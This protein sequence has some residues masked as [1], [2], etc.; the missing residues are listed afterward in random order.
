LAARRDGNDGRMNS[1][2]YNAYRN[3][4][5]RVRCW[6][7]SEVEAE[8]LQDAAEALLLARSPDGGDLDE[9]T[10]AASVVIDQAMAA[11]RLGRVQAN[12]LRRRLDACGPSRGAVLGASRRSP[13]PRVS[14]SA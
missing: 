13:R 4:R 6:G 14:Q 2:R 12:E 8:V 10:V 9:I 3:V 1:F 7:F 5:N 11:R